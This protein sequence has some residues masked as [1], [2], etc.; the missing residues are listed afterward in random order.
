MRPVYHPELY[1][2][3][4]IRGAGAAWPSVL[5][6]LRIRFLMVLEVRSQLAD[7]EWIGYVGR[8]RF[9]NSIALEDGF[10]LAGSG[11]V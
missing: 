4:G 3:E 9:L 2:C 7:R 6:R 5:V 11:A 8:R 1:R 10:P